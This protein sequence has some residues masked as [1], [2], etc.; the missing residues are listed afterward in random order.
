M[1]PRICPPSDGTTALIALDDETA[2]GVLE[3]F[4]EMGVQLPDDISLIGFDVPTRVIG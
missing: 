3:V 4:A 1:R 2:T